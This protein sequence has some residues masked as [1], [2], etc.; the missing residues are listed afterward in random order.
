MNKID[1][2][3]LIRAMELLTAVEP[4][5]DDW[6]YPICLKHDV[7]SDMLSDHYDILIRAMELLTAV[8]PC[9]DDWNYP[10]CLKHDVTTLLDEYYGKGVRP[11][12]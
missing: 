11:D 9:I 2:D 12:E 5:I 4:C 3:I 7:T 6:N 10:I 8:E 1:L